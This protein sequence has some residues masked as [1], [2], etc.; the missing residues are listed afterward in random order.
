MILA[1]TARAASDVEILGVEIRSD[2]LW[3]TFE[4]DREF[5]DKLADTLDRGFSAT[6][7]YTI[8]IWQPRRTWFD[9]LAESIVVP[10]KLRYDSWSGEYVALGPEGELDAQISPKNLS[11]CHTGA[12]RVPVIDVDRLKPDRSYYLHLRVELQPLTVEEVRELEGWLRGTWSGSDGRT[13]RTRGVSRGLFGLV[14]NLTGFGDEVVSTRS[15]NF[16]LDEL[17]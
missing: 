10:Y 8:E 6:L 2:S 14:K 16:N 17:R 13:S 1:P 15:E 3:M 7:K 11:I 4:I 5:F 12:N 9:R